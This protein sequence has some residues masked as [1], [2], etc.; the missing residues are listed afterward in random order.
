MVLTDPV[1]S[2]INIDVEKFEPTTSWVSMGTAGAL[3]D[4]GDGVGQWLLTTT[5]ADY[6]HRCLSGWFGASGELAATG[7]EDKMGRLNIDQIG[8]GTAGADLFLRID[9][10][11]CIHPFEEQLSFGNLGA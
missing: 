11:Q 1:S 3:I 5:D 6:D 8:S 2:S 7:Q 9:G 10:V 4:D